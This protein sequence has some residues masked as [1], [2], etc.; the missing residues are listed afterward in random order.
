MQIPSAMD[1]TNEEHI[2]AW[3]NIVDGEAFYE[4]VTV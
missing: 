4:E 3:K 2:L 1:T